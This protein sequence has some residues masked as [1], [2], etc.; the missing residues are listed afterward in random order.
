M[1]TNAKLE[2]KQQRGTWA[3]PDRSL[4]EIVILFDPLSGAAL[5]KVIVKTPCSIPALISD[6]CSRR[7]PQ[8][9]DRTETVIY[10]DTLRKLEGPRPL[11]K[12]TF[13][14]GIAGFLV[15]SGNLVLSGDGH[16][17][18]MDLDADVVLIQAGEF[19]S[20]GNSVGLVILVKIHSRE[21]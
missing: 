15:L 9:P 7:Y 17:S 20:C 6:S 13:S 18:V 4:Q 16:A 1:S 14:N 21:T 8:A 10:L 2:S 19:E 3:Y 12:T 5:G 11:S